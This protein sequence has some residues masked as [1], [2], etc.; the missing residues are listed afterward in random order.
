[1]KQAVYEDDMYLKELETKVVSVNDKFV[2]LE[3]TIFYPNSGGVLYDT[4]K[5]VRKNDNKVFN[6]VFSVKKDNVISHEVDNIG[7]KEGDEVKLFL[8][9]DRR[10]QLMK[11]HTVAHLLSS[12]FHKDGALITGNSIGLEK[13]RMDFNIQSFSRELAEEKINLLNEII[14]NDGKVEVYYIDREEALSKEGFVKLASKLPPNI[15]VLRI[16]KITD[17]DNNVLDEQA[18]GGCHVLNLNE[19]KKVELLKVDNK[20][21]GNRRL[22]FKVE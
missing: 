15:S 12:L 8:D 18:D 14:R 22:Y 6:V 16:V 20:G 2:V 21:K 9:W 5:I 17:L 11:S 3:Q 13:S 10:Y 7:L 4:G 1:M 19:I